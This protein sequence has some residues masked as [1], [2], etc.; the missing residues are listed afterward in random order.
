MTNGLIKSSKQKQRL[1]ENVLKYKTQIK[2]NAYKNYKYLF[3]KIKFKSEHNYYSSLIKKYESNIKKTWQVIKE[4]TGKFKIKNDNLPRHIVVNNQNIYDKKQI[5]NHFNN[6]FTNIGP[7]LASKIPAA[8]KCFKIYLE[9]TE[10]VFECGP[11]TSKE[12][13]EA[14]FLFKI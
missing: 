7:N 3:E 4:I 12:F 5:A 10:S 8:S 9:N 13:E 14:C 2:E 1:Y 11:L 6:F